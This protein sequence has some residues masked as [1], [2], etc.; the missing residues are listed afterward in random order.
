MIDKNYNISYKNRDYFIANGIEMSNELANIYFG[1]KEWHL[2]VSDS[3]RVFITSDNPISIY[4]PVFVP[5]SLNAGLGNG[6]LLLPISPK[7]AICLR[8]RPCK[9]QKL[10]L[11]AEKVDAIN[12]NTMLFSRNNIFS[13]IKSKKIHQSYKKYGNK[14]FVK[15]TVRRMKWAP[16]ILMGAPPVPEELFY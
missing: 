11:T 13:N 2:F 9:S 7:L 3:E 14:K 10:S 4:R 8:D 15:S 6:T 5:K 16:Y 1:S 12:M